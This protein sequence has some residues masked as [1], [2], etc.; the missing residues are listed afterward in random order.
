MQHPAQDLDKLA[1]IDKATG[2]EA[3]RQALFQ[4]EKAWQEAPSRTQQQQTKH[5]KDQRCPCGFGH[6]QQEVTLAA[7]VFGFLQGHFE[8]LHYFLGRF[9]QCL[10]GQ[11]IDVARKDCKRRLPPDGDHNA[12]R[13]AFAR[14][15]PV[16]LSVEDYCDPLSHPLDALRWGVTELGSA[17]HRYRTVKNL[18]QRRLVPLLRIAR[19]F[20][21]RQARCG[22]KCRGTEG[23]RHEQREEGKD[24]GTDEESPTRM[25]C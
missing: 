24:H 9:I 5:E 8:Q 2:R 19:S 4:V 20:R 17:E 12:F 18:Q 22:S 3:F 11:R 6:S 16:D 25:F 23:R 21:G 7:L 10:A 13:A 15:R 1:Q 14:H